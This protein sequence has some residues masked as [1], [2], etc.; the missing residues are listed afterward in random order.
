MAMIAFEVKIGI[1][2]INKRVS[3]LSLVY[4]PPTT[5]DGTMT[6]HFTHRIHFKIENKRE[7]EIEET[8]GILVLYIEVVASIDIIYK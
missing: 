7:K 3:Q 2:K 6:T 5:L 1:E 4:L 8:E